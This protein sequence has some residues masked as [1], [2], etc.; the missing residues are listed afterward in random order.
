[1]KSGRVDR[2]NREEEEPLCDIG[3]LKRNRAVGTEVYM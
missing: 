2:I 1:M 3:E